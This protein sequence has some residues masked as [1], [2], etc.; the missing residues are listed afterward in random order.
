LYPENP[1]LCLMALSFGSGIFKSELRSKIEEN[2]NGNA[3]YCSNCGALIGENEDFEKVQGEVV[4][5]DCVERH[6]TVCSVAVVSS[7][8]IIPMA[9]SI[10]R[11]AGT[12]TKITIQGA[13][14]VMHSFTMMICIA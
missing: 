5:M 1:W 4:C 13:A 14:A 8:L 12:V 11:F 2:K 9:M 10:P 3:L 7:G 6:T